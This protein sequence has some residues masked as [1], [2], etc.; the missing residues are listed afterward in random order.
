MNS[1]SFSLFIEYTLLLEVFKY[2]LRVQYFMICRPLF[3]LFW[4]SCDKYIWHIRETAGY[5]LLYMKL[6]MITRINFTQIYLNILA[7][8]KCIK[9]CHFKNSNYLWNVLNASS[10]RIRCLHCWHIS[11]QTRTHYKHSATS[12]NWIQLRAGRTSPKTDD[13]SRIFWPKSLN[14]GR[15]YW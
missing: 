4:N 7:V 1:L 13:G 6:K 2:C 14:F 9:E 5:A 11:V 10:K 12:K 8:R 3:L 15:S